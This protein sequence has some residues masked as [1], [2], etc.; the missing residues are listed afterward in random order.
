MKDRDQQRVPININSLLGN[1]KILLLG[2]GENHLFAYSETGSIWAF[3][4]NDEH[5]LGRRVSSRLKNN[6]QPYEISPKHSP[7]DSIVKITG[8]SYHTLYINA[9]GQIFSF[10]CNNCSQLGLGDTEEHSVGPTR[11][12][13]ALDAQNKLIECP[14]MVDIAAGESHSL[15]LS[16]DGRIF[17]FGSNVEGQLGFNSTRPIYG[18]E[19]A[20][21]VEG[22]ISAAT[23]GIWSS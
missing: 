20:D 23:Q 17:S 16:A 6:L 4:A 21:V 18:N 22:D 1:R 14:R 19:A 12:T 8:G 2:S 3:G 13:H 10:G 11:V 5:Q 9:R 7:V 15:A